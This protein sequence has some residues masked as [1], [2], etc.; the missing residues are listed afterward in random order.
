LGETPRG[1]AEVVWAKPQAEVQRWWPTKKVAEGF[2]SGRLD[3]GDGFLVEERSG[4]LRNN[5]F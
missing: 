4:L 1:G 3:F 5:S 2:G